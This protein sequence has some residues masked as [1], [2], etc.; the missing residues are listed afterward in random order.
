MNNEK[1]WSALCAH[2]GLSAHFY[3]Y[4]FH[5]HHVVTDAGEETEERAHGWVGEVVVAEHVAAVGD[6]DVLAPGRKLRLRVGNGEVR[7]DI[8]NFRVLYPYLEHEPDGL[9]VRRV[10]YQPAAGECRGHSMHEGPD[11]LGQE[12]IEHTGGKKHRPAVR[13]DALKPRGVVQVA[14]DVLLAL[15]LRVVQGDLFEYLRLARRGV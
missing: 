6:G 7:T 4:Y 8:L 1:L 11:L 12:I 10:E 9:F 14:A 13:V 15:L 5:F 3:T 2:I